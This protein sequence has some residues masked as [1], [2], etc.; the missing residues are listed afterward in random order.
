MSHEEME[1]AIRLSY[2][3]HERLDVVRQ[4]VDRYGKDIELHKDDWRYLNQIGKDLI[5]R[6]LPLNLLRQLE[7]DDQNLGFRELYFSLWNLYGPKYVHMSHEIYEEYQKITFQP[8]DSCIVFLSCFKE[9]LRKFENVAGLVEPKMVLNQL[10]FATRNFPYYTRFVQ[11]LDIKVF[12]RQTMD[13][14]YRHLVSPELIGP[15]V[16]L[17]EAEG[18]STSE[19]NKMGG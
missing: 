14:V 13:H 10:L 11:N 15:Y 3:I 8:G 19:I 1:L 4:D 17:L 7:I 5:K 16:D 2:H 6:T 12:D 18:Y 9:A